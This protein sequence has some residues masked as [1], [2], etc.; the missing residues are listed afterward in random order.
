MRKVYFLIALMSTSSLAADFAPALQWVKTVGGSGISSVS[1]AAADPHGNL[2]M[3]GR[4]T[5]LDFP[6]L[7]AAQPNAG[8]SPLVRINSSTGAAEKLYP[9]GL[10]TVT[11]LAADPRNPKTLYAAAASAVF[12]SLDAGSTWSALSSIS[13]AATVQGLTADLVDSNVLYAATSRQGVLKSTD[14]G[15]TWNAINTGIPPSSDGSISAIGVVVDPNSPQVLFTFTSGG[16][17]RSGNRGASWSLITTGFFSSD[18]LAFDPFHP[19]TLYLVFGSGMRR[20]T[21]DGQ[22]FVPYSAPPDQAFPWALIADPLHEGILYCATSNGI[23]QSTDSGA[24]WVQKTT[25]AASILAADPDSPVIYTN[26]LTYAMLKTTDGFDT[27]SPFGTPVTT[28]HQIVVAGS[29]V[30]QVAAPTNDVFAVKLD[31]DGNIVYSTYFGGSSDDAA[32]AMTLGP[33]GSLYVTGTA[34]SSDFPTTPGAYVRNKPGVPAAPASFVFKLN[35][36]GSL[37]WS[38]YFADSGSPVN[39]IALDSAGNV[40]LGGS[41]TGKLPTTPG[42]YQTDFQQTFGCTGFSHLCFPGPTSA[43]VT[44]FNPQGSGLVYSTYVPFDD[45]NNVSSSAQALAIDSHGNAWFG[46]PETVVQVNSDGSALLASASQ[47]GI[48]ISALALDQDSNLYATGAAILNPQIVFP[49]TPGAFQAAPQPAVPVLPYQTNPGGFSDAFVIKW[50]STLSHI[51]AATLLGGELTDSGESIALD[52]AGNVII[53][54]EADS[55]AFPTRAPFQTS[56]SPRSGFVAAFDPTLSHLLFSTYLGDTRPFDARAVALDPD[57]NLLLAGSTLSTG[58][59][60]IGGEPGESFNVGNLVVANK[61]A[62]PAA[63]AVRLDSVKN[64]ASQI[65]APIAPGE[66][67]LAVGSGFAPDAQLVIDGVPLAAV[68]GTA[69]TLLAVMPDDAKTSGAYTIQVSSGGSLSNPVYVPA[70]PAS[71]GIYSTDGTGFGQGYI[72]NS[73]GT[74]N[75]PGNPA[76]PGSAIT[77]FVAGQGQFTLDHGFAVTNLAPSV[78]VEGFYCNG[79][80]AIIG[81]VKGLPGNVY[82]LSVFVPDPV[83][84]AKNNPDLANFKFPPQVGV[85]LVMGPV[86]SLNSANSGM[87]SQGGVLLNV[88]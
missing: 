24:N 1:S 52:H 35:P 67:I 38:T 18:L 76:T 7:S 86:N 43:F 85:Q 37:A 19:G 39:A 63:P 64:F 29:N 79:I 34:V 50:D 9:P 66:P 26:S 5:S 15:L 21:D 12:H 59:L 70:A 33:D 31:P 28:L 27:T 87:L 81:P 73:D 22:T 78:F 8:G 2:Y 65:A 80:A 40:F 82:Q 83:N 68:T 13:P 77:L 10:S 72:L 61:I 57:G 47:R 56:F 36:D 44:K 58:N 53:S 6:G 49:A 54:G 32:S 62:L 88:K 74:L 60:F 55:K 75:S 48:S 30:F 17:M 51:L 84:L 41:S 25:S 69:S 45:H 20:S 23:Y 3:V 46:G 71:P 16:F 42:A 11:A 4:T 14:G